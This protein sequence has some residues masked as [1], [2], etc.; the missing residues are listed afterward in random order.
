MRHLVLA[1]LVG[2]VGCGDGFSLG[3]TDGGEPDAVSCAPQAPS[4][5]VFFHFDE[6]DYT[7]S[8]LD[9]ASANTSSI[10]AE[11]AH[12]PPFP[13]NYASFTNLVERCGA[14]LAPFN[15]EVTSE[16]PGD[17]NHIELL[18]GGA[19]P[20]RLTQAASVGAIPHGCV[21]YRRPI[22]FIDASAIGNDADRLCDEALRL[23]GLTTGLDPT[24]E[25]TDVMGPAG[26]AGRTYADANTPC[27]EHGA[28][29]QCFCTGEPT[30]NSFQRMLDAYGS[31][32]PVP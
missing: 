1:A 26:I 23:I 16:N 25:P 8:D 21:R 31:R 22:G 10:L 12:V 28:E 13:Y 24:I 11:P 17:V 3:A 14:R 6:G 5:R 2:L 29:P 20:P 19:L 15:I 7:P 9:D 18:F 27:G 32:C 30:Q 4:Q